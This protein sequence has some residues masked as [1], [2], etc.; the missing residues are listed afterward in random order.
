MRNPSDS[1]PKPGVNIYVPPKVVLIAIAVFL[2]SGA[3]I[4][5]V[6][7]YLNGSGAEN[8]GHTSDIENR[9]QNY[10]VRF[11]TIE[12]TQTVHTTKIKLL[13]DK[14]N[15]IQ[16]VQHQDIARTEARRVTEEIR[17]REEREREFDRLYDINMMRLN[18]KKPPCIDRRCRN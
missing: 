6:T 15:D 5:G 12:N 2:G 16:R 13:D 1:P 18:E 10:N 11:Q 4:G 7:K 17:N 9:K 3:G 14:T 8:T